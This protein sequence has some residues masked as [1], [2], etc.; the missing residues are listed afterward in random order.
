VL[1][2]EERRGFWHEPDGT[3]TSRS[4][5]FQQWALAAHDVLAETAGTYHGLI[6]EA[7]LVEA[8]QART[9]IRTSQHN[10]LTTVLT[11]VVHLCFRNGEPPLTAL[12]VGPDRL[13]G[14]RY[15]EILRV[16]DQ[17]PIT[18]PDKRER[19]AAEA[20]LACYRWAGSAPA[21][22]GEPRVPPLQ[23][24]PTARRTT[25]RSTSPTRRASARTS[26]P[27]ASKPRRVAKSDQPV[28]VCPSCFLALP[29]TGV[30]DNC[31]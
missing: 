15:D 27:K 9:H 5:A 8:V 6:T 1:S 21:D 20:Q 2:T 16:S 29:A 3:P 7:E 19:H 14:E 25:G 31:S 12:V 17:S 10:W 23:V 11:P 26:G 4:I 18:D 28:T 22:G 30:C 13:V 24:T